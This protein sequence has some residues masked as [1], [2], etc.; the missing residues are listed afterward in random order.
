VN[1][2]TYWI[3]DAFSRKPYHGNPA[4]IVFEAAAIPH[5]QMQRIARYLNLS[6]TVFLCAPRSTDADYLARIFTP[7]KEIPFAGHPTV[8]AAFAH[9]STRPPSSRKFVTGLAQECG[10]GTVDIEVELKDHEAF[11]RLT[12]GSASA[13]DAGVSSELAA[14]M[15]GCDERDLS[16]LP[17][18]VCSA[19][20][21]WLIVKLGSID[22]S[23]RLTP[24]QSLIDQVCRDRGATGITTY[25]DGADGADV[26]H[27]VR[28]FAPGVGIVEDPAC[29]SGNMALAIHIA[30][31]VH[32]E[33][34]TLAFTCE[35]GLEVGRESLLHL[36]ITRG[37]TG[38][39]SVR[40]G[41]HAARAMEGRLVA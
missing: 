19:G 31:H 20:L 7:K 4:A 40:L 6:E 8:A 25:C 12:A 37:R 41:G 26:Q 13:R 1:E 10:I 35:Q 21:P 9:Y 32:P 34:S 24:D 29:G 38:E 23:R 15:L 22:V 27:H 39:L 28:T 5:E 33:A 30:R 18:E 17:I 36:S 3:V 14:R 11:F 2:Y 16:D